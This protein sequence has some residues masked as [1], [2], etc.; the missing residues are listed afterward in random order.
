MLFDGVVYDEKLLRRFYSGEELELVGAFSEGVYFNGPRGIVLI[1]DSQYGSLPFGIAVRAFSGSGRELGLVPGSKAVLSSEG[2]RGIGYSLQVLVSPGRPYRSV[3]YM[4]SKESLHK[5]Y[6]I[7]L[8]VLVE[9]ERASL[10]PYCIPPGAEVQ[11]DKLT[12]DFAR[13]G[14][15]HMLLFRSA[16]AKNDSHALSEALSGLI[17]LGR[18]LTPSF[19]DFLTGM[20]FGRLEQLGCRHTS[21][22]AWISGLFLVLGLWWMVLEYPYDCWGYGYRLGLWWYPYALFTPGIAILISTLWPRPR[23]LPVIRSCGAVVEQLGQSSSEILMIHMALF[24]AIT[25]VTTLTNP[26]WFLVIVLCLAAGV[27]YHR[28]I[29]PRLPFS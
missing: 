7:S 15:G 12:D 22:I 28:W 19:D 16:I 3:P 9:S 10:L 1:H 4:P 26:Q 20:L 6:R 25:N 29:V 24:K 27:G 18:G 14:L 17:G 23:R 13:A 8:S 11:R 21:A 5:L 2:L